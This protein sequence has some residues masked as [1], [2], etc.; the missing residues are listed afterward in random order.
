MKF[1]EILK[2]K[3]GISFVEIL[4]L[5]AISAAIGTLVFRALY[6]SKLIIWEDNFYK[7]LGLD[8][9]LVHLVVVG[10]I[11]FYFVRKAIKQRKKRNY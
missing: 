2:N 9:A 8:P 6:G 1:K 10:V 3:I 4:L 7:S 5:I 11:I